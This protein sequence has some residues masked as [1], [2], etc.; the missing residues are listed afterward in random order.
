M[1]NER[2]TTEIHVPPSTES[3]PVFLSGQPRNLHSVYK[4]KRWSVSHSEALRALHSIDQE[5]ER[6]QSVASAIDPK[7]K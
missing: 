6:E 7:H 2:F 4:S 5:K 3:V 1:A